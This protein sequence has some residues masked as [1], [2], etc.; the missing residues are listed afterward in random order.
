MYIPENHKNWNFDINKYKFQ[1][2]ELKNVNNINSISA[3]RTNS[4]LFK[5]KINI[6]KRTGNLKINLKE[7]NTNTNNNN[8]N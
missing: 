7:I 5:K 6:S 1:S 8:N 2:N 4:P 3:Q